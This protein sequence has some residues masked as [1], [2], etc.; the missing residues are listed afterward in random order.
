M[1]ITL[2][3]LLL[4]SMLLAACNSDTTLKEKASYNATKTALLHKEEN[5][6]AAF[7]TV[8]G[9]SKKNI[10]GQ[11]VVKGTLVNK[12]SVATFKDVDIKLS[13]YSK[14]QA[15]LETDKETIFEILNPGESQDFKT[16]YFAPKGTD[17]VGLRVLGAK[18]IQP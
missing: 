15:L 3:F 12:A 13:F 10:V 7:I 4:F 6:P 8:S 5:D 14:T 9:N 1:R 17:S 16:K 11:T 2:A 18:V